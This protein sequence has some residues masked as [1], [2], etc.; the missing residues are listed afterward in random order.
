VNGE[1][2]GGEFALTEGAGEAAARIGVRLL[3]DQP[4][5]FN[6]ERGESHGDLFAPSWRL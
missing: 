5:A 2:L 6:L 4:G 1:A 3:L